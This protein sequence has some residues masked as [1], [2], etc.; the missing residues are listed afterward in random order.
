MNRL[1]CIVRIWLISSAAMI[2][3]LWIRAVVLVKVTVKIP[4]VLFVG[5]TIGIVTQII[6][7]IDRGTSFIMAMWGGGIPMN[8]P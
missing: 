7:L 8:A 2:W 6:T 3:R 1:I 5:V 4:I